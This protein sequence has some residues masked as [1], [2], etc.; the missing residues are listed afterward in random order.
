MIN[1]EKEIKN[2]GLKIEFIV[3]IILYLGMLYLWTLPFQK[4]QI[5]YG[6]P[7]AAIHFTMADKIYLKDKPLLQ[8]PPA[9]TLL[10]FD[11]DYKQG[12]PS[13]PPQFYTGLGIT[14]IVG[15]GRVV[16]FYLYLAIAC[17][18]VFFSFYFLLRKLFGPATAMLALL[19][20]VFSMRDRLTYLWGQWATAIAFAFIPAIL[21]TSYEYIN[22]FLEKDKKEKPLYLYLTSVLLALQ[23]L[24][25]AAIFFLCIG[26]IV[27]YI[28]AIAIKERKIPFNIKTLVI[29][30][31]LLFFVIFAFAPQQATSNFQRVFYDLGLYNNPD[32]AFNEV[33]LKQNVT[34]GGISRIFKWYDFPQDVTGAYPPF[35]FSFKS[36]YYSYWV[37]P[38][39]IIGIIFLVLRRN[40]RDLLMLSTIASLYVFLHTDVIGIHLEKVIR[41]FYTESII[42]YS[43]IAI[44]ITSI[45]NII[46]SFVKVNENSR[47]IMKYT[48]IVIA[49]ILIFSINAQPT[50][51]QLKYTY[52]EGMRLN[53]A[54]F[55]AANWIND[56]LPQDAG[57]MYVGTPTFP[58]RAWLEAVSGRLGI[59]DNLNIIPEKDQNI[60]KTDYILI[61]YSFYMVNNEQAKQAMSYLQEWEKS[62]TKQNPVYDE[63]GIK[64]FKVD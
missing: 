55:L 48:L 53:S 64:I 25:H 35:L 10:G 34:Y 1:K 63:N 26:M 54:E 27:I 42:F 17:S 59:F 57:I 3:L 19:F 52:G 37:L 36:I 11:V 8:A 22:S 12:F 28:I 58:L 7:D 18:L 23:F 50:Y 47:N 6:E 2:S 56:N 9:N 43:L 51:E 29:G 45:P 21:Y 60:N 30:I 20:F 40:R 15:G 62:N 4:Q 39:L 14:E 33:T 13:Y 61:D 46:S 16:P 44:G 32:M 49:A 38:F 5:P 24:F 41:F 31:F